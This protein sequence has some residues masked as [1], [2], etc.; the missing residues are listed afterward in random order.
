MTRTA[1]YCTALA[2]TITSLLFSCFPKSDLLSSIPKDA[3]MVVAF[4]PFVLWQKAGDVQ[5]A[6]FS[7]KAIAKLKEDNRGLAKFYQEIMDN[8]N[9]TGIHWLQTSYF[10]EIMEGK[11]K[12]YHALVVP[13]KD[14]D[15]FTSSIN[16]LADQLDNL[17]PIEENDGNLHTL[18]FRQNS[19]SD[20]PTLAWN[21]DKLV[22]VMPAYSDYDTD[23][24]RMD[25]LDLATDLLKLKKE[26]SILANMGFGHFSDS[27]HDIN[28][29]LPLEQI[30]ELDEWTQVKESLDISLQD[31]YVFGGIDFKKGEIVFST[32][33]AL[34]ASLQHEVD[35]YRTSHHIEDK[36]LDALPNDPVFLLSS[37]FNPQEIEALLNEKDMAT[38]LDEKLQSQFGVDLT[39]LLQSSGGDFVFSF[40]GM[41]E[42][43]TTRTRYDDYTEQF[44]SYTHNSETPSMTLAGS[45]NHSESINAIL[46]SF[47]KPHINGFYE[48]EDSSQPLYFSTESNTFQMT[49]DKDFIRKNERSL[50]DESLR[51]AICKHEGCLYIDLAKAEPYFDS[52]ST[53]FMKS[54][55]EITW[56][57]F[58][59]NSFS[60]LLL[61]ASGNNATLRLRCKARDENSLAYLLGQLKDLTGL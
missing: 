29:W 11:D 28:Y 58:R 44:A 15:A 31:C 39:S 32:D 46:E 12:R 45:I 54:E 23:R 6:K 60:N 3:N 48:F 47:A 1:I 49:T 52:P 37:V 7:K 18:S 56:M 59:K 30:E 14:G 42:K 13:L 24:K 40:N 22:C 43:A 19:Y 8:P 10:F 35:K 38:Q 20:Y 21:N 36:L 26:R 17:Q 4:N 50:S 5:D 57:Q 33:L 25:A 55:S 61:E 41:D 2:I 9:A 16:E 34:N 51:A 53:Y 27:K